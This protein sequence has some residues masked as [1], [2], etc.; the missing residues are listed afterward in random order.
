LFLPRLSRFIQKLPVSQGLIAFTFIIILFYGW[1]A[2]AMGN[3]AAITGAFLAGLW[4]S[5]SPHKERIEN[6]V[7][8][9]AYGVFVP[10][11][12]INVGLAANGRELVGG[13]LGL[14]L[15]MAVL[16]VL[17]KVLGAG[18]GALLS[19]FSRQEALQL[20]VGMMSRGEVG[21]IVATVGINQGLINE[22]T[23][24]AIVG[25]V[26]VTTLLT[27]PLLRSLFSKA[28]KRSDEEQEAAVQG[29]EP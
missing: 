11:F 15:A 10:I 12:F 5:R 2:E 27:P 9:L 18:L 7:S 3:M 21:L 28:A 26:I 1:L 6:G 17:S 13:S 4:L 16:A 29:D 8:V 22:S 20:G 14:F 19:G 25:V 24:A 23:F